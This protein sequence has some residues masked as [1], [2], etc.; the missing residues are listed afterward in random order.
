MVVCAIFLSDANMTDFIKSNSNSTD[1]VIAGSGEHRQIWQTRFRAVSKET[2][3]F[4]GDHVTL[5]ILWRLSLTFRALLQFPHYL[6]A[7]EHDVSLKQ[8]QITRYVLNVIEK[9]SLVDITVHR[10]AYKFGLFNKSNL[11]FNYSCK[12]QSWLPQCLS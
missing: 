2:Y 6:E 5:Y 7:A 3:L 1:M 8:N 4:I 11:Y 10:A 12:V 9:T